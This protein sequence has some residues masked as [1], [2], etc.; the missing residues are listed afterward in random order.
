MILLTGKMILI[1]NRI[2]AKF[3]K[4]EIWRMKIYFNKE[5]FP[6]TIEECSVN[7]RICALNNDIE[8]ISADFNKVVVEDNEEDK[9][10]F[11]IFCD[12]WDAFIDYII[13][14][15]Q[16]NM[17]EEEIEE[18]KEIED[19][20]ELFK[21]EFIIEEKQNDDAVNLFKYKMSTDEQIEFS[22]I[23]DDFL[24]AY[25]NDFDCIPDLTS[26]NIEDLKDEFEKLYDMIKVLD[27]RFLDMER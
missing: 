13:C 10:D 22:N 17:T 16:E 1:N 14:T 20:M 5:Q 9:E 27:D 26:D 19:C 6:K 25:E 4:G 24:L 11:H 15:I 7:D 18:W 8:Y 23:L 2:F 3:K 21:S 12:N